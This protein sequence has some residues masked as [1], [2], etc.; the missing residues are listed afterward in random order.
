MPTGVYERKPRELPDPLQRFWRFVD[1]TGECWLWTGGT[2]KGYGRFWADQKS[3]P[4]HRYIYERTY[5]PLKATQIVCHRCDHP[6]CVRL[7]HLFAG[8][9]ADN[10]HDAIHKGRFDP[11]HIVRVAFLAQGETNWN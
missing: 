8:T 10:I 6:L 3:V 9:M 1:R 7:G 11:Q 5:G 4:A 2:R